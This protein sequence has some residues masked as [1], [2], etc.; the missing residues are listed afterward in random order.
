[1][2]KLLIAC[3]EIGEPPA[4]DEFIIA[5]GTQQALHMRRRG[6]VVPSLFDIPLDTSLDRDLLLRLDRGLH[7]EATANPAFKW[8][9]LA[10]QQLVWRFFRYHQYR[11]RLAILI[12]HERPDNLII[13]SNLDSDLSFAAN[14]ECRKTGL[15]LS[16]RHGPK[17]N[18]SSQA[19]FLSPYDLIEANELDPKILS[20]LRAHSYHHCGIRTLYQPCGYFNSETYPAETFLWRTTISTIAQLSRYAIRKIT[21]ADPVPMNIPDVFI[22]QNLSVPLNPSFWEGFDADDLRAIYSFVYPFLIRYPANH[23]DLV[24]ERLSYFLNAS[25]VERVVIQQDTLMSA[26][27]ISHACHAIG[28]RSDYLPHGYIMEE[29]SPSTESPFSPN[30]ILAWNEASRSEFQCLNLNATVVTHPS[31]SVSLFPKRNL[32]RDLA[33]SKILAILPEWI[34]VSHGV[35]MD[36]LE[37]Y[38]DEI[39]QSLNKFGV[40]RINAKLH[41]INNNKKLNIDQIRRCI[42]ERV[43]TYRGISCRVLDSSLKSWNIIQEHDFVIVGHTTGIYECMRSST[44]FIIYRG[45]IERAQGIGAYAFPTANN[46]HEL[47]SAIQNYDSNRLN[48]VFAACAL[49]LR[50]G[51]HPLDSALNNL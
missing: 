31:N 28:I 19:P 18:E 20:T 5:L 33:S 25:H 4:I 50:Q 17:D 16:L 3:G 27:L 13:S 43:A 34:W 29:L 15:K 44:P 24:Y 11:K 47:T 26:R 37:N 39:C 45:M 21:G 12:E 32:P 42:L 2:A 35:R 51:P 9:P 6:Y 30:R 7:R 23:L 38:F 8:L 49:S 1:M 14:A 36:C 41:W 22:L 40:T 48:N 10:L 46:V